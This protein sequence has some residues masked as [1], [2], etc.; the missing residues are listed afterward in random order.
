[1][2]TAL[3]IITVFA[4]A[5]LSVSAYPPPEDD[6]M[7]LV[8]LSD[9]MIEFKGKVVEVEVRYVK[10]IERETPEKY[11]VECSYNQ[12]Q[13]GKRYVT[14]TIYFFA[15]EDGE[16]LEFFED[17]VE[18]GYSGSRKPFYVLVEGRTLTAIGRK[19]KKSKGSYSW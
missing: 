10:N 11:S 2:R 12:E 8:Q 3:S 7:T 14:E 6:E 9:R 1:M 19:Y 5:A 18:R 15:D 13:G 16:A 4:V 17:L